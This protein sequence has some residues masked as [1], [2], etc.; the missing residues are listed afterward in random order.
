MISVVIKLIE[1][2]WWIGLISMIAFPLTIIILPLV[3]IRLPSDYFSVEK[4]DGFISRQKKWVRICLLVI[5]NF[6]GFLLLLMGILMLFMPGQGVLTLFAGLSIMNFP[7]KR[8]LELKLA[9]NHTVLKGLNWIRKKGHK[10]SF[11]HHE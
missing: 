7:G 11:I 5:K 9:L 4:A 6:T 1:E 10:D 2:F 8:K 3:V